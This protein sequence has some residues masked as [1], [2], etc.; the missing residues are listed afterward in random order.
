MNTFLS[1]L[2]LI[3]CN[4]SY[5]EE[6]IKPKLNLVRNFDPCDIDK[7]ITFNITIDN[8]N[9]ED[10][11]Y[12]FNLGLKYDTTKV[13]YVNTLTG[14]SIMSKFTHKFISNDGIKQIV[15]VDGGILGMNPLS[16]DTNLV[17]FEFNYIADDFSS[18][19]F[20]IVYLNMLEGYT[21]S[22]DLSESN[23]EFSPKVKDLENRKVELNSSLDDIK[24]D[25]TLK[26]IFYLNNKIYTDNRMDNFDFKLTYD[27]KLISLSL[28]QNE[29]YTLEKV[30]DNLLYDVYKVSSD[31]FITRN[32]FIEIEI[33]QNNEIKEELNS[34]IEVEIVDW[35]ISSCITRKNDSFVINFTTYEEKVVKSIRELLESSKNISFEIYNLMGIKV[36]DSII[37]TN[38]LPNLE[39]GLYI[40]KSNNKIEKIIIN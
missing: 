35:D 14:N 18:A 28:V 31:N 12:G 20:S 30:D 3:L 9:K 38:H 23:I 21:K 26:N 7:R 15:D 37:Y 39:K 34:N 5:G 27:K 1:I 32:E 25:S 22:I 17:A 13:Q 6:G 4:V 16:G 36:Y 24:I 29:N 2:L 33:F 19:S 40:I 8:I 10:S 11:L